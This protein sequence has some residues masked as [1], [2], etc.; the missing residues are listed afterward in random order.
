MVALYVR[1][2]HGLAPAPRSAAPMAALPGL[3]LPWGQPIYQ[4][5]PGSCPGTIAGALPYSIAVV[6]LARNQPR[7]PKIATVAA[8]ALSI[9]RSPTGGGSRASGN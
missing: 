7:G 1:Y 9:R 4:G 2:A 3:P 6:P 5:R 8:G